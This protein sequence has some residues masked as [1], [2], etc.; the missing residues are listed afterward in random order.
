MLNLGK[1]AMRTNHVGNNQVGNYSTHVWRVF[2]TISTAI[3]IWILELSIK[4]PSLSPP[5]PSFSGI[6]KV[7]KVY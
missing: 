6:C 2:V 1:L 7:R 4:S 5:I 3:W